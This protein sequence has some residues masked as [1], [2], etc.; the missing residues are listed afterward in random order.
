MTRDE[1]HIAF[2]IEM[3]KNSQS[4]AYGGCPAFLPEEVDYWLNK[5]YYDVLT[6]KFSGQNATQ[7]AFEGSVK[8]IA[9]LERLVK[10]DTNISVTLT[11]GTNQLVLND[12]LNRK[13]NN[14]GRMFFIQAILHWV[15]E[16]VSKSSVVSLIDHETSKRFVETYNNKPWIDIPVAVIENNQLIIYIDT[17]SMIGTYTLDITYVK[18]PTSITNLPSDSGLTEVP[19]YVQNEVVNKAVQLALDNIE[20][21]RVQTKS[22]LNTL[23]D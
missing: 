8:R 2:K 10:T 21:Q 6:T 20:S 13:Q 11:E 18:H 7:T 1:L 12:L 4:V 5:G 3:D 14:T 17:T 16:G 19:E 9:D 22:Q 23:I 15:N